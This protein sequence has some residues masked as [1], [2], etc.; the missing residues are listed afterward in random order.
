[1]DVYIK[2]KPLLYFLMR[3]KRRELKWYFQGIFLLLRR[4]THRGTIWMPW[5]ISRIYSIYRENAAICRWSTR[6]SRAMFCAHPSR[7]G[8]GEQK[9]GNEMPIPARRSAGLTRGLMDALSLSFS[10]IYR[11]ERE[12]Q[13]RTNVLRTLERVAKSQSICARDV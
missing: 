13:K 2:E 8:G 9:R 6:E 5:D 12:R 10:Y 1:M 7:G 11:I 3:T 4:E